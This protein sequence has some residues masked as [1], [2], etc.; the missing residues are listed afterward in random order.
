MKISLQM[1]A[2]LG[3]TLVVTGC[4]MSNQKARAVIAAHD[5]DARTNINTHVVAYMSTD[6]FRNQVAM[7]SSLTLDAVKMVQIRPYHDTTLMVITA[8]AQSSSNALN[9]VSTSI[10]VIEDHFG[11]LADSQR[12]DKVRADTTKTQEQKR[13]EIAIL[14][15]IPR[16]VVEIVEQPKIVVR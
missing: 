2:L 7:S 14:E 13:I 5:H 4:G 9:L 1:F 6:T 10:K 15:N 12:V 16:S 8:T 11:S 3:I